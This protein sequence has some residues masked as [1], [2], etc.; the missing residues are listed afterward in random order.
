MDPSHWEAFYGAG[1]VVIFLGG[2][3]FALQRL[4]FRVARNAPAA[5]SVPAEAAKPSPEA[6]AL[7][8]ATR[9]LVEVMKETVERSAAVSR[10]HSRLDEVT[11]EVHEVKGKVDQANRTLHLIEE[12]LINK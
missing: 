9:T 12:H 6:I 11:K 7:I 1:S 4:G 5:P 2:L 10:V 8:E 3:I